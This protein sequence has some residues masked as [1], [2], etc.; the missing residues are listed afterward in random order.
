MYSFTLLLTLLLSTVCGTISTSTAKPR[1]FYSIDLNYRN[2]NYTTTV[3]VGTPKQEIEAIFSTTTRYAILP[4][5][6][7]VNNKFDNCKTNKNLFDTTKSTS[8][9]STK[10]R[11][12]NNFSGVI[13]N[14][15]YADDIFELNYSNTPPTN[16]ARPLHFKTAS[17]TNVAQGI[18]A[19]P[20]LA[21]E[22][23]IEQSSLVHNVINGSSAEALFTVFMKKCD[24]TECEKSGRVTIGYKD[25]ENC[26]DP[27]TWYKMGPNARWTWK[28]SSAAVKVNGDV[29]KQDVTTAFDIMLDVIE[30]PERVLKLFL[31]KIEYGVSDD[32][33]T[34]P[35]D[36]KIDLAI[37]FKNQSYAIP[38][39]KLVKNED[40]TCKLLVRKADGHIIKLGQPWAVSYCQ[41]FDIKGRDYGISAVKAVSDDS[42]GSGNNEPENVTDEPEKDDEEDDNNDDKPSGINPN[43]KNLDDMGF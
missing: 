43:G 33:Y 38:Q 32:G 13:V 18:L 7:C 14:G 11:F 20:S 1:T 30:L 26:Q 23:Y 31:N 24:K 12:S 39:E 36:T 3:G 35:C 25:T 19:L 6:G 27:I 8:F 34:V 15:T 4:I 29:I 10:S 37:Q 5:V 2:G 41:I 9:K 22:K 16:P 21:K 28:L 40:G 42:N 17:F